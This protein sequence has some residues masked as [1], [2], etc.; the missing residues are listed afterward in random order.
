MARILELIGLWMGV[1]APTYAINRDFIDVKL[2]PTA[3]TA[4]L[5]TWQSGGMSLNSFLYQL[6]R[7]ELL[8][9][10]VTP[11]KEEARIAQD[12]PSDLTLDL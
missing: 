12:E 11:E 3:L 6:Q 1:A 9:P 4:L 10:D 7:G 8:P 2:D 5:K